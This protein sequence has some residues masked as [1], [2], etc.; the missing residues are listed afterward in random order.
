MTPFWRNNDVIITSCINVLVTDVVSLLTAV[1]L[2]DLKHPQRCAPLYVSLLR[3]W[4]ENVI[5]LMK[6]SSLAALEVVILTTFSAASDENFIKMTTF[7]FQW[8]TWHRA[9][10]GWF[11]KRAPGVRNPWLDDRCQCTFVN[12]AIKW[13]KHTL[14]DEKFIIKECSDDLKNLWWKLL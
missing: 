5:I 7:P 2:Y 10:L 4:N 13:N 8:M 6:F 3:H 9:I 14:I 12:V 11:Y 1:I